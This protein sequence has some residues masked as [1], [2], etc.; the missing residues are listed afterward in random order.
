MRRLVIE[1]A[2]EALSLA[3]FE[4][5][6]LIDS[7]DAVIGRGHAEQLVPRIA[8]LPDGGKADEIR[9]DLG[10][11]S[12]TGVRIGIAAARALAIAWGAEV[13]GFESSSLV[14]AT[15]RALYSELADQA[16]LVVMEGGHGEWLA[17]PISP[18]ESVA[19]TR[20]LVPAE[21]IVF[22]HDVMVGSRAEEFVALRGSGRAYPL[23]PSAR[24]ADT[25]DGLLLST[26][27]APLYARA[28][29]ATPMAGMTP[30]AG[31]VVGTE[32]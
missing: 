15:A 9:V 14:A 25:I 20:S 11:G 18:T 24:Y 13:L 12:F 1:T 22:D 29:D 7:F 10:P 19:A 28:P 31:P 21:A 23:H 30:A 5:G 27:L 17:T 2:T 4:D 8:D 3:L 16:F 6:E 26:R 32:G